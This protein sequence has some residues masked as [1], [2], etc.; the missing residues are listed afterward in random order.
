VGVVSGAADGVDQA[1]HAGALEAGAE[2]WAFLGEGL[3]QVSGARAEL[4]ATLREVGGSLFSPFPPGTPGS[5]STFRRRN[6]LISGASDCVL[7]VRAPV[8]SGALITAEAALT[9]GR[10]LLAMPGDPW[11]RAAEGCNRLLQSGQARLCL[12]ADEVL[13]AVG[14]SAA[15]RRPAAPGAV[16]SPEAE[17]LLGLLEGGADA[18]ALAARAGVGVDRA[19]A[20]LLELQLAGAVVLR[21]GGRYEHTLGAKPAPSRVLTI[22]RT[23]N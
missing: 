12:S 4:A 2:T 20:L 13:Q 1:A 9:Q 17:R 5:R 14:L 21:G 10:P 6:P 11:N 23:S 8:G 15:A 7:V 16:A 22:P 3:D 19:V 18:D